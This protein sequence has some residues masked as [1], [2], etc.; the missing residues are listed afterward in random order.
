MGEDWIRQTIEKEVARRLERIAADP[1]Q[2]QRYDLGADADPEE[3]RRVVTLEVQTELQR[4]Q[5][6]TL[7]EASVPDDI[8]KD[9]FELR[10]QIGRGAQGRTYLAIDR[11]TG[12][13][14]AVKELLLRDVS[15]WKAIEL[16]EREGQT[17]KHLDHPGIPYYVDAF[18]LD[19]DGEERFFLVQEFVDG[20]DFETLV[21]EGLIVDEE[22][23]RAFL[24]ELLEILVYLQCLS[25]PVIHRDIK[26]SNVMRHRDGSLALIDFGA[27]Q[28]VIPNE[29]GGSTI[30]GTSGYMP[31]E[32][33][34]GRATPA[35]DVYAAGA[36]VIHLLSRRHPADLPMSNLRLRF[37]RFVNIS[38]AFTHYLARMVAPDTERRFNN[39]EEALK[40]LRALEKPRSDPRTRSPRRSQSPSPSANR[41]SARAQE[42]DS[43]SEGDIR[44]TPTRR[45]EG[46]KQ[47]SN[48]RSQGVLA[49]IYF[50]TIFFL[51]AHAHNILLVFMGGGVFLLLIGLPLF[52]FYHDLAAERAV[53]RGD[54]EKALSSWDRV[55]RSLSFDRACSRAS[56]VALE[57][58]PRLAAANAKNAC[59]RGN[60]LACSNRAEIFLRRYIDDIDQSTHLR[61]AWRFAEWGCRHGSETGCARLAIAE[62]YSQ[63][64]DAAQRAAM[65]GLNINSQQPYPHKALGLTLVIEGDVDGAMHSFAEASRTAEDPSGREYPFMIRPLEEVAVY[66]LESLVPFHPDRQEEIDEAISRLQE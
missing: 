11:D 28:S 13:K 48:S 56:G 9:R 51:Q 66:R 46:V 58:D 29:E 27:V 53:Q 15:D 45:V 39:A 10:E 47:D 4:N 2:R 65:R 12:Q 19:D 25:P 32:Q 40:V 43:T 52:H 30:I 24:A 33:L 63:N 54:Y 26:P 57:L 5:Q 34:M 17:L 18:H 16:F 21:D 64:T 44:R 49:T 38:P 22:E 60:A 14:V 35:T 31:M 37:E 3:I 50:S 8:L 41:G 42:S 23:A 1:A 6:P 55:C 7:D 61:N 20:E 62:L 59:D 36:T